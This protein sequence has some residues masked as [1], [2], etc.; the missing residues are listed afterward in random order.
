MRSD[1]KNLQAIVQ[2][3]ESHNARCGFP[4]TAVVMNRFEKRRLGWDTIKGIPI[5][6]DAALGTGVFRILCD[7]SSKPDE[8]EETEDVRPRELEVVA[9]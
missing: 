8:V 7:R 4:A 5:I 2:A 1:A 9:A 6:E 3:I